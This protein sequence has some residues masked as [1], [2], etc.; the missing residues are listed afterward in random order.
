M[1][2]TDTLGAISNDIGKRVVVP[3]F[4]LMLSRGNI[5]HCGAFYHNTVPCNIRDSKSFVALNDE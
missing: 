4:K 2:F 1:K 5:R 3:N